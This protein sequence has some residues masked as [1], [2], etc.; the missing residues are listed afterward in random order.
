[1]R[2][3][4]E[5]RSSEPSCMC[6]LPTSKRVLSDVTDS[7]EKCGRRASL[8][9]RLRANSV[10]EDD[11]EVKRKVREFLASQA[12]VATALEPR[13]SRSAVVPR[14]TTEPSNNTMRWRRSSVTLYGDAWSDTLQAPLQVS[15]PRSGLLA[16]M[17]CQPGEKS[18][19]G[20]CSLVI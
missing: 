19:S 2:H 1:M 13:T 4:P 6:W 14:Q 17:S 9:A 3:T 10:A 11:G 7:Q 5:Q 18:G 16:T 20:P 8:L 12:I 15:P